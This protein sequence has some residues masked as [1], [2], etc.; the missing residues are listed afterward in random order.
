MTCQQIYVWRFC[1]SN[2]FCCSINVEWLDSGT[3]F[4][5]FS[6]C[7]SVKKSSGVTLWIGTT[8]RLSTHIQT[9]FWHGLV[10]FAHAVGKPGGTFIGYVKQLVFGHMSSCLESCIQHEAIKEETVQV[11][12]RVFWVEYLLTMLQLSS[13]DSKF[14]ISRWSDSYST[15]PNGLQA[16]LKLPLIPL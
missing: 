6:F 12:F 13:N 9:T 11:S 7:N 16:I 14:V 2:V 10:Y 5:S 1:N 15:W 3:F 8:H 4:F